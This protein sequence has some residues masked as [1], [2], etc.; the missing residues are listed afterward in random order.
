MSL[1]AAWMKKWWWI[2]A[3]AASVVVAVALF[4]ILR[5]RSR[6]VVAT[7]S[8]SNRARMEA[9]KAETDATIEKLKAKAETEA[10]LSRLSQIKR[11]ENETVRRA[12]LAAYLD[13]LL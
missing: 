13:E 7:E 10:K 1:F 2:V 11:I 3:L 6:A 4:L 5:K 12:S 9:S 8:F